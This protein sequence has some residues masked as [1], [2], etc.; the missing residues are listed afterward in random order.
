MIEINCKHDHA[1]LAMKFYDEDTAYSVLKNVCAML[2]FD[3]YHVSIKTLENLI[4][5]LREDGY[6][7]NDR[8]IGF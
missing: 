3:G 2:N 7:D 5:E 1:E 4:D 6:S 8:L